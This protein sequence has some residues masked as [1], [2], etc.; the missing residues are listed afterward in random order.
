MVM[1]THAPRPWRKR[2]K[3]SAP[4]SRASRQI[5]VP[6]RN[7]AIP[8][9]SAGRR[10]IRSDSGPQNSCAQAKAARNTVM[11]SFTSPAGAPKACA[12]E[13]SEGVYMAIDI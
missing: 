10:P 4:I 8:A 13:G 12:S 7:T 9:N 6:A 2:P 1:P 5:A 11:V 3:I